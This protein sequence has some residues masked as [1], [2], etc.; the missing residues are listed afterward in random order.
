MGDSRGE[1]VAGFG[2]AT[3]IRIS[4]VRRTRAKQHTDLLTITIY[5]LHVGWPVHG[6]FIHLY[7]W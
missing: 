4:R 2:V 7:C 1:Q 3:E 5:C 6:R